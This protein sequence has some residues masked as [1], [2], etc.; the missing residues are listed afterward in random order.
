MGNVSTCYL[1]DRCF[2]LYT[3]SKNKKEKKITGGN[4]G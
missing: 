2:Y 1:F 4:H 3:C